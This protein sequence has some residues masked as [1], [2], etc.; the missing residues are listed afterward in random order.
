MDTHVTA[1]FNNIDYADIA[2]L[3]I[4]DA[5]IS[6]KAVKR[7]MGKREYEQKE[8]ASGNIFD[9]WSDDSTPITCVPLIPRVNT[10][11]LNRRAV[12]LTVTVPEKQ[13]DA[14]EAAMI[15]SGGTGIKTSI[16]S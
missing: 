5:G 9:D 7:V 13:K 4:R 12:R 2:L 15:N 11:Y 14:V 1:T 3:K 6:P 16:L 10:R 8:Y